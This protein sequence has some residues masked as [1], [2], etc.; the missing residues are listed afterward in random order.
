MG[1]GGD[2]FRGRPRFAELVAET[3]ASW[4][5]VEAGLGSVLASLIDVSQGAAITLFQEMESVRARIRVIKRL[6]R[7]KLTEQDSALINASLD[8][9]TSIGQK[10][11]DFAHK[12]W[13]FVDLLP[14]SILLAEP[15]IMSEA[16]ISMKRLAEQLQSEKEVKWQPV[17]DYR[18]IHVYKLKDLE[19]V[20]GDMQLAN[21]IVA[22]INLLAQ[23][24][25][26]IKSSGRDL[27]KSEP[28]IQLA[29][30]TNQ[31]RDVSPP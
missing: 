16:T 31:T 17:F 1:F 7:K 26:E 15:T 8:V 18:L 27:L 2:V 9:V 5:Q 14:D 11:H 25:E 23:E 13:G 24:G 30:D 22:R 20:C 10:R 29:L 19:D 3:I 6:A 21:F 28:R 12:I 4:A